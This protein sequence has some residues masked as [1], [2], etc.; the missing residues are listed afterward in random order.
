MIL[1]GLNITAYFFGYAIVWLIILMISKQFH[2]N[3]IKLGQWILLLVIW[4]LVF[5]GA[6]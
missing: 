1:C 3:Y 5:W 6:G 4:G 2:K